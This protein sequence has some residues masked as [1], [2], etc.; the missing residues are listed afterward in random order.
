MPIGT[1]GHDVMWATEILASIEIPTFRE[2]LINTA[3]R[4]FKYDTL[5]VERGYILAALAKFSSEGL[6]EI[7]IAEEGM[8]TLYI[9]NVVPA[10]LKEGAKRV[11]YTI[12]F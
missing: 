3:N 12:R 6:S 5:T 8:R 4:F 11:I 10:S 7:D 1:R 2:Q 9:Q